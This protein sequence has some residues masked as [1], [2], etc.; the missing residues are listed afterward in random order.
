MKI[1][2]TI[3]EEDDNGKVVV[4]NLENFM[5]VEGVWALYGINNET[6]ENELLNVG[7]E[8]DVGSEI[9]YD[10][11]CLHYLKFRNDGDENYVNQFNID[12]NF[13]YKSGQTQEYLYPKLASLY[14]SFKFVY[15]HNKSDPNVEK[16]I[17]KESKFWRNGRPF[18]VKQKIN[19]SSKRMQMIEDLFPDGGEIYSYEE[20]LNEIE[21]KLGYDVRQGKRLI[22]EWQNAGFIFLMDETTYTR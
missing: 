4:S 10:I 12:C 21:S 3:Y 6:G 17:A 8:K 20:L 11:G 5:R 7:K 19:V 9:L 13:K 15:A 2:E 22:T 16:E 14:N 18:G 1:N